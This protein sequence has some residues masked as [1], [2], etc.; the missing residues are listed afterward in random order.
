MTGLLN[1]IPAEAELALVLVQHLARDHHSV[2]PDLL[3][4]HTGFTVVA[5]T[6]DLRLE[7]RHV[8]VIPPDASM[9]V[10]DGSLRVRQG[11][12]Q[13][14]H[15]GT[16]DALFHSVA[17]EYQERAIGVILSGSAHDGAAGIRAIKAAGG[18][19][20]VQ[21]PTEAGVDGMPRAAIATGAVDA[22]L[23]LE[24]IG[25]HLVR[26][27]K[28]TF[29][30][31]EGA[32]SAA[33]DL[34]LLQQVFHLLRRAS[35]V[36]FSNYKV[37]TLRRRIERRMLLHRQSDLAEY[38]TKLAGDVEELA[39]LQEELLIHVTSFFREPDSY[40]ALRD[41]AFPRLLANRIP[42]GP[43]RF[44]VPG[45]STGEEVYSL[46]MVALEILGKEGGTTTLQIFG[47]DVSESTIEKARAGAYPLE[48]AAD[49]SPER[50]H[51]F[52]TRFDGGYRINKDVRDRCVFA[53]QD[54]T[55]DPPF[56]KLDLIVCRN[57]LI[58]L[59]QATQRR[60]LSVFHYALRPEGILMLGRSENIGALADLFGIV[61]KRYQLYGKK[62]VGS[63]HQDVAFPPLPPLPHPRSLA[64]LVPRGIGP[65]VTSEGWDAQSDANRF[66]LDRYA[67]PAVIVDAEHRVLRSRG[68]TGSFLELPSGEVS[69]DVLRM[70]RPELAH[71]LRTALQEARTSGRPA[72][73]EQI[74]MKLEGRPVRLALQVVPV[75]R[76]D[77]RQFMV[78]FEEQPKGGRARPADKG[79][80]TAK[81]KAATSRSNIE[82]DL[83][84][85]RHQ[86]QSI[87]DDL[88]ASNEELQSANEEILSSNEELQS[89]NE[90]LDTAKEEMQ[91]T[92]EELSTLND[93]LHARNEEL[94]TLNSDLLNLLSSVQIPIVMVSRDLRIRRFTPAAERVMNIIPSDVGRPIGHLKPNFFCPDLEGLITEVIDTMSIRGRHV[95]GIDGRSFTLQI[96]PYQNVDNRIDGAVV[97][98]FDVS[99]A[100]N[101]AVALEVA[102]EVAKTTGDAS[103]EAILILDGDLKVLRANRAARE[104][105]RLANE[106]DGQYLYDLTQGRWDTSALQ[107]LLERV[108]PEKQ[109]VVGF[110]IDRVFENGDRTKLLIDARRIESGRRK[111][112]LI[113]LVVRAGRHAS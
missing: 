110:A 90:E 108:L 28:Q 32:D 53:R 72:S 89:T 56:S 39:R 102:L 8:Y 101:Q 48:I 21:E 70:A 91:S 77:S 5:A 34:P 54:V 109:N 33:V 43:V 92:N 98:M 113:I 23:P 18:L 99:D 44:W 20:I 35:G 40:L 61:D 65:A 55:R 66:L 68:S 80:T 19:T 104:Q 94:S 107:R 49:V 76:G 83:A 84:D 29:S 60:V 12:P 51:R 63:A 4:T 93:E 25:R 62:K 78:L 67:P 64:G 9:T 2:L 82:R 14:P 69:V 74:R 1:A 95:D 42:E 103:P 47:T 97:V 81:K 50:L 30:R 15:E 36:D 96:R 22:V 106:V 75:G 41:S 71:P 7:P 57:L 27:S 37:A 111:Q 31:A 24:Q 85:T 105:L 79:G 100:Q 58:Y 45:C 6:D 3:R 88:A 73:K 52:F 86:L 11:P 10:S 59:N 16:V 17:A 87:I 13:G 26:L 112:G 46:A 38:V